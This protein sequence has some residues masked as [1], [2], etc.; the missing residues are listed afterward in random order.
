M[1]VRCF[2][3]AATTRQQGPSV[4]SSTQPAIF[5]F[6][7]PAGLYLPRLCSGLHPSL[8]CKLSMPCQSK[9]KGQHFQDVDP[10]EN[11]R[12]KF[13]G[14]LRPDFVVN[15]FCSKPTGQGPF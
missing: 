4:P 5:N 3:E 9:C 15:R 10:Q 12:H 1:I 7:K 6:R 14:K 13:E 8:H 2:P 11:V